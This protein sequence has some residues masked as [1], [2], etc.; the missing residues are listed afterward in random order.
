MGSCI[1]LYFQLNESAT[2]INNEL[3]RVFT[4]TAPRLERSKP[5][6]SLWTAKPQKVV[7]VNGTCAPH[8]LS[9]SPM[10]NSC[11]VS[12]TTVI[13]KKSKRT[14]KTSVQNTTT[15]QQEDKSTA[16][17]SVRHI[18]HHPPGSNCLF[19]LS[20]SS[21]TFSCYYPIGRTTIS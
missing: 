7:L 18:S 13:I 4:Y 9:S 8:S 2:Q 21:T 5:R 6:L 17:V 12:A 14:K 11:L 10:I 1:R 15:P 16:A 3:T 19:S 20:L